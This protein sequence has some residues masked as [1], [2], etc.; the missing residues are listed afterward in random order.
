MVDHRKLKTHLDYGLVVAVMLVLTAA[1][2]TFRPWTHWDS[3]LLPRVGV[4]ESKVLRTIREVFS[5]RG[6]KMVKQ[7]AEEKV[8]VGPGKDLHLHQHLSSAK[9]QCKVF[10]NADSGIDACISR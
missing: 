10:K 4:M 6:H 9:V 2:T 8:E 7:S 1:R 5:S 3:I